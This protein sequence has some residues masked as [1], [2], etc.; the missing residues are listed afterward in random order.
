ML[1][2]AT[3][4]EPEFN[5]FRLYVAELQAWPSYDDFVMERDGYFIGLSWAGEN[6]VQV[7]VPLRLFMRWVDLTGSPR[8]L[9]SVDDFAMRRWLRARYPEWNL[10]LVRSKATS[11]VA[12]RSGHLCIPI[13]RTAVEARQEGILP[14]RSEEASNSV[15]VDVIAKECLDPT[16]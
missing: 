10:H 15:L 2:L 9:E 6:V 11:G 4:L 14:V 12:D 1:F 16:G 8:S 13:C 5:E 7:E 3:I